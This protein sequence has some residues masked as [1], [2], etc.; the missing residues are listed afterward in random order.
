[1]T[2]TILSMAAP[3]GSDD[4]LVVLTGLARLVGYL[5]FVLVVGTT[6]FV[7]WI[8]PE[9]IVERRFIR[10]FHGGAAL[11]FVAT[12]SVALLTAHGSFSDAFVGREGATA[13]AR[14][15]LISI[16]VA[17]ASDVLGSARRWRIPIGIW[18]LAVIETVVLGS[19]A[20]DGPWQAVKI[21][22]TTGHL[23]ATAAWLGGLLTLAAVLLPSNHL[24]VLHSVLPTFSVIAIVSVLT[25]TATGAAHA[26]AVAGSV[27]ALMRSSYGTVLVVK[28]V[29]F[30]VMLLLGNVGRQYAGRLAHRKVIQLDDSASHNSIRA[31]AV[32]IGAELT[33]AMAVLAATAALVHVGTQG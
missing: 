24:D 28:V 27:Q 8:W 20:W 17:F 3:S 23:A 26:L 10:L 21:T 19:D 31:F 13:L 5:G 30:G 12:V 25:L 15:S 16:A 9:E 33:L 4:L 2:S 1:M 6:F 22:A 14:L 18:Q 11:T 32:A 7:A 29:V